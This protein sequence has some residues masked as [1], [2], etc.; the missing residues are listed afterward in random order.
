MV[1]HGFNYLGILDCHYSDPW[2][3]A[4]IVEFM[5]KD[6]VTFVGS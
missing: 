3:K 4:E 6:C 5:F 2:A 1:L